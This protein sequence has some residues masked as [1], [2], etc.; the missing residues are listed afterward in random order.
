MRPYA[1]G[2][3]VKVSRLS[4]IYKILAAFETLGSQPVYLV[5][6]PATGIRVFDIFYHRELTLLSTK[7]KKLEEYF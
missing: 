4:G 6:D 7:G 1:I 3:F 2:T 5:V